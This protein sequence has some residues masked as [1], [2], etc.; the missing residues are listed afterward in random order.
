M[1]HV[2]YVHLSRTSTRIAQHVLDLQAMER[3]TGHPMRFFMC[4]CRTQ[5]K[6]ELFC[7]V[8]TMGSD[9]N[10]NDVQLADRSD[11][12]ALAAEMYARNADWL[13]RGGHNEVDRQRPQHYKSRVRV[14]TLSITVIL[15]AAIKDAFSILFEH[16]LFHYRAEKFAGWEEEGIAGAPRGASCNRG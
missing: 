9:K 15:R 5:R 8:R 14:S 2:C 10:C 7:L 6:E 3:D 11:V 1:L 4:L 13:N 16:P 12:A